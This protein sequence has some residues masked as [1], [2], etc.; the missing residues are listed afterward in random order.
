MKLICSDCGNY[1]HFETDVEMHQPVR[2]SPG[3]LYVEPC[4]SDGYN[5][6][7]NSVL[8]GVEEAVSYCARNDMETLDIRADGGGV[9]SRYMTCA[10]CGS[11]SV[12]IPYCPWTP[13]KA[14]ATMDEEMAMNRQEF[15]WLR[16]EREKHE[17]D[18]P[19]LP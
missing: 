5:H 13:P 10:R 4:D 11:K 19:R 17:T 9:A 6:Q 3:G 8:M 16:K 7:G 2:A 1:V 14:Y 15:I 12:T 18:M